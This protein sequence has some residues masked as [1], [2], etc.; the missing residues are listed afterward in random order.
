MNRVLTCLLIALSF[1]ALALQDDKTF[2]DKNFNPI[3]DSN[4][5]KYYRTVQQNNENIYYVEVFYLTDAPQ[6][7]G[8][9]L[10]K[11]L[12]ILHGACSYFHRN[13]KIE[14]KGTFHE[15]KRAGIWERYTM[16]GDRKADRFYPNDEDIAQSVEK[17]SCLAQFE[18]GHSQ[19][20]SFIAENLKFPYQAELLDLSEGEVTFNLNIDKFG[21]I[22]SKEIL[23]SSAYIFHKSASSLIDIMPHWE[24]AL[25]KGK[26]INSNFIIKIEFD[27]ETLRQ[28]TTSF[29]N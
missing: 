4:G 21:R 28:R 2:L 5:A 18:N 17:K 25:W 13:G 12:T 7:K 14:S 27:N 9:Y 16:F 26:A 22:I 20:E 3:K 8:H 19:L 6:M 15:G 10:D 11:E 24:P 1:N 29:H 23:T